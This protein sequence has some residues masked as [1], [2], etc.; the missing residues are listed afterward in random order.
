LV[1]TSPMGSALSA[2]GRLITVSTALAPAA[3]G[4]H[5]HID[6]IACAY[7]LRKTLP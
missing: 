7:G 4:A 3:R 5:Q 1:G 2:V 6:L